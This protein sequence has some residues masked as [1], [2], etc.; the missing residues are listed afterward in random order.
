[1]VGVGGEMKGLKGCKGTVI[2]RNFP[3]K[4]MIV[5]VG[6]LMTLEKLPYL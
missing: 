1:M 4:M 6:N 3:Y 5:W 2:C